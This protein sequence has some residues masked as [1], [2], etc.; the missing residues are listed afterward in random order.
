MNRKG[1]R[2]LSLIGFGIFLLML[3]VFPVG[4]VV[5]APSGNGSFPSPTLEWS[6]DADIFVPDRETAGPGLRS[7]QT[8]AVDG[9]I[10]KLKANG[11]EAETCVVRTGENGVVGALKAANK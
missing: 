7:A 2:N 6:L 9:L 4:D 3:A 1:L 5:A 10:A 11:A 8:D